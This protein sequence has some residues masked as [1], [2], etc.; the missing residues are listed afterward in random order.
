[1]SSFNLLTVNLKS[2]DIEIEWE[3]DKRFQQ[4]IKLFP[5]EEFWKLNQT[6][7]LKALKVVK[8]ELKKTGRKWLAFTIDEEKLTER[9]KNSI[10]S[11]NGQYHLTNIISE[12]DLKQFPL[13]FDSPSNILIQRLVENEYQNQTDNPKSEL[14]RKLHNIECETSDDIPNRE[15]FT[16]ETLEEF[17]ERF[18]SKNSEIESMIIA[19]DKNAIIGLSYAW[20][21]GKEQTEIF[22]TGVRREYRNKGVATAL[23]I[24]LAEYLKNSGYKI[25][26]TKNRS[27]NYAILE[28]NRKLGFKEV[29]KNHYFKIPL[30]SGKIQN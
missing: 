12:L 27:T 8:E 29:K 3:L 23:K 4:K 20:T 22:F 16:H 10:K 5:P 28:T 1:M 30:F 21:N 7:Q 26:R 6:D 15:G 11:F 9:L 14:W 13:T 24:K 18:Q 2:C 25:L 17:I 19:K